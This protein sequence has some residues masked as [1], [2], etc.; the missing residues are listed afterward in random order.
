[1][2][3]IFLV[4]LSVSCM[5]CKTS[6]PI[7]DPL[8]IETANPK[9]FRYDVV[10]VLTSNE[11]NELVRL[12]NVERAKVKAAPVILSSGLNCAAQKHA[13][14]IGV[15]KRCTHTGSNGSSP[16]DRAKSCGTTANGE[17]V[18]C[19]HQTPAAAVKGWYNSSGHRTIMLNKS[20]TRVGVGMLNNYWVAIFSK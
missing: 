14:D 19:G 6:D 18:A 5:S 4:C 3:Y 13:N 17:I 15:K 7:A 9:L 11:L 10:P 20:Y 2:R 1:M 8:S 16:W 12:I